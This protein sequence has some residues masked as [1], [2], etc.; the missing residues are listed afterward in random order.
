[1]ETIFDHNVTSDEL[2]TLLGSVVSREKYL[3]SPLDSDGENGML[4]SL[5]SLRNDAAKA[6]HFLAK[7]KDKHLRFDLQQND[8]IT[9]A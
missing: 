8:I 4:Y 2:V 6:A 1:M 5:Y 9:P 7:V 3:S